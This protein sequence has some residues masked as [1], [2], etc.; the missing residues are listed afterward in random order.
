MP[1]PVRPFPARTMA[2]RATAIR[3]AVCRQ[4]EERRSLLDQA[5]DLGQI[6]LTVRL[7]AGTTVV[8]AVCVAEERVMRRT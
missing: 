6:T 4:I 3:E 1:D 2:S 8:K 7:H 5:D